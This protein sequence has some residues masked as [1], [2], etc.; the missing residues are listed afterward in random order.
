LEK[1]KEATQRA[2]EDVIYDLAKS[3]SDPLTQLEKVIFNAS[4]KAAEN[5]DI[6]GIKLLYSGLRRKLENIGIHP[7][8]SVDDWNEGKTL[9]YNPKK[10][11]CT[12]NPQTNDDVVGMSMGLI[13]EG[14]EPILIQAY[15]KKV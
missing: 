1:E 2:K 14:N 3:I 7:A 6:K 12:D 13:T 11:N 9:Q 10:H 15:V 8:I 5:K 4:Q